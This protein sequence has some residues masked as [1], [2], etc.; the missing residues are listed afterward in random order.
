VIL[1]ALGDRSSF[2]VGGDG[3]TSMA[4]TGWPGEDRARNFV[5]ERLM[6]TSTPVA[7]LAILGAIIAVLG[8]FVVGNIVMVVIGLVAVFGGGLLDV[9]GFRPARR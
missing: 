9:I 5:S 7:I 4:G 1:F 2:V 3:R 6:S 8:L